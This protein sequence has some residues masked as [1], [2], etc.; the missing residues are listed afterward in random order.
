MLGFA[1]NIVFF[2]VNGGS[3]VEKSWLA[4]VTVAGVVAL[5]WNLS[6]TAGAMYL[7]VPGDFF[8]SLLTLCYCVL[9]VL[10]HFVHWNWRI[11]AICSTVVRCKSI[12]FSNSVCADRSGMAASGC[13][14]RY[15]ISSSGKRLQVTL[16]RSQWNCYIMDAI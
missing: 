6:R 9:H 15:M 1:R 11:K 12:V 10:R 13:L 2:R 16:G 5:P 14:E 4:C 7:K 3:V 8:S